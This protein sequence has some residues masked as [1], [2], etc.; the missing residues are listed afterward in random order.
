MSLYRISSN[1]I[2]LQSLNFLNQTN[3][4]VGEELLTLS[5]GRRINTISDDPAGYSLATTLEIRRTGLEQ[6]LDN[7]ATAQNV[8]S[9]AESGY[10]AI[11]DLLAE[12]KQKAIQGADD[13]YSSTERAALQ[14]QIDAL[15][16]EIDDI[17]EETTFND[18]PLIDGSFASKVFQTGASAGDTFSI[19]LLSAD[20][21]ALSVTTLEVS[22]ADVASAAIA[23]V[24]TAITTL[25]TRAQDAGE[26]I[27]RL[28]AKGD[29]LIAQ[30]TNVEAAR[31]RIQDADLAQTQMRLI[32][33]QIIQQTGIAAYAQANV[34]PQLILSLF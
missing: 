28:E 13:S 2:A 23:T 22:D 12:I 24:D 19:S 20:S 11:G 1:L 33:A 26:Y 17:V 9:I 4:L 7:V 16:A 34:A 32:Q 30:S 27:T 3:Q 14:D 5:S 21:A 15:V 6:A 10:M 18:T 25:N 29:V 8:M 31:S